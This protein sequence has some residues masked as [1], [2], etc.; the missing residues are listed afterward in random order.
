MAADET[1][2]S[3][4]KFLAADEVASAMR[5]SKRTAYR[6]MNSGAIEAIRVG[7]SLRVPEYAVRAG[8]SPEACPDA[9][10]DR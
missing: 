6:L 7:R 10:P 4:I 3:E 9:A 1:P 2:L 5:V 8:Q